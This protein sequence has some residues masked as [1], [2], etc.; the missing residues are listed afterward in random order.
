M[1]HDPLPAPRTKAD[2]AAQLYWLSEHMLDIAVSMEHYCDELYW[3]DRSG[4]LAGAAAIAIGW[5]KKMGEE[6]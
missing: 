6:G 5:A 4:E 3:S 2:I 1:T